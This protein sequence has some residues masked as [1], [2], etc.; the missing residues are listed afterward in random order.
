[1][2]KTYF[3]LK[4]KLHYKNKN[5]FYFGCYIISI[6]MLCCPFRYLEGEKQKEKKQTN[7]CAL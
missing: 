4:Q 1:M 3:S 2:R 7:S 6:K 5:I